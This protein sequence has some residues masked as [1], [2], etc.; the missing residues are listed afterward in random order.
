MFSSALCSAAWTAD[1]ANLTHTHILIN[2]NE[3]KS[4]DLFI[5]E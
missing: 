3:L 1:I 5:S 4:F 2:Q